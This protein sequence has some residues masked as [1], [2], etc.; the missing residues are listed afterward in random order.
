MTK[1]QAHLHESV[2]VGDNW[3]FP[4]NSAE[5]RGPN[6]VFQKTKNADKSRIQ[7]GGVNNRKRSSAVQRVTVHMSL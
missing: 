1:E 4:I 5:L 7:L 3:V 6:C 2:V